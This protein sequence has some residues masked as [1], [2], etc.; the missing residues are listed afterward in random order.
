MFTHVP[1]AFVLRITVIG[2]PSGSEMP[3]E[4]FGFVYTLVAPFAGEL[5]VMVGADELRVPLFAE[6]TMEK[7]M[8]IEKKI[9]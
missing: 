8:K 6:E 1:V 3:T 9:R 4:S 2:S 7:G 5:L